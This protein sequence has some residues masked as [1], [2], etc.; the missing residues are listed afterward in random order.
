MSVRRWGVTVASNSDTGALFDNYYFF[1]SYN[2]GLDLYRGW[3]L[4]G[5]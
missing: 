5:W 2:P 1:D 4:Q 3:G